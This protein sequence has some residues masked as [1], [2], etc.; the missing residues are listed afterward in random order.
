MRAYEHV[1]ELDLAATDKLTS[2]KI[3]SILNDDVN[4][5]E[6]F[7]DLISAGAAPD[8]LEA[9]DIVETVDGTMLRWMKPIM[10]DDVCAACHGPQIDPDLMAEIREL[11]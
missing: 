3:M 4:Q 5:L 8:E 1:Q 10:M 7:L 6:R 9:I 11:A 2:G